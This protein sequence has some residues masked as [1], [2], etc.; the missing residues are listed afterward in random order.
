M[1]HLKEII[2]EPIIKNPEIISE[3]KPEISKKKMPPKNYIRQHVQ[4]LTF[5][6]EEKNDTMINLI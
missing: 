5:L 4:N 3:R 1:N 2:N 6:K